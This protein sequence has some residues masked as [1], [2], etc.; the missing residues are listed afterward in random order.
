MKN[1][2]EINFVYDNVD[3]LSDRDIEIKLSNALIDVGFINIT[4]ISVGIK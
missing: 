4:V 3:N 1:K 2:V